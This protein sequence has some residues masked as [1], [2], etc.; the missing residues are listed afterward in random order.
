VSEK[1]KTLYLYPPFG[2]LEK[3]NIT[4]DSPHTSIHNVP[5]GVMPLKYELFSQISA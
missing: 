5:V 1:I 3:L 2:S 4:A